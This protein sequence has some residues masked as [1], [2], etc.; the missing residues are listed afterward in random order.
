LPFALLFVGIL[1]VVSGVRGT[2]AQLFTLIKGDLSGQGN[3]L[4]WILAIA[5]V[6]SLGYIDELKPLSRAFLVLVILTL[7]IQNGTFFDKFNSAVFAPAAPANTPSA[8]PAPASTSI[9][10]VA[11]GN[12]FLDSM[13][14]LG[15]LFKKR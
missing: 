4:R 11:T 5:V 13:Q 2:S 3:Y 12:V 1:L 7:V 8:S 15:S 6:G 14:A 10:F 9:P